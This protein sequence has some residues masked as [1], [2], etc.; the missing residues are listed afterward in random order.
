M[1]KKEIRQNRQHKIIYFISVM[2]VFAFI[3]ILGYFGMRF[4]SFVMSIHPYFELAFY[5]FW[6]LLD[7]L[8]T[9]TIMKSA[10]VIAW[11]QQL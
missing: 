6:F 1:D 7:R 11:I 8:L 9:K 2:L 4:L 5:I 10:I 3:Y